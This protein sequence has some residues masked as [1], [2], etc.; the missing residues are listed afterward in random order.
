MH[1]F[2][3][4]KKK[5]KKKEIPHKLLGIVMV[6]SISLSYKNIKIFKN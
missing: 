5:K 1:Y 3:T 6:A 4:T 2:Q